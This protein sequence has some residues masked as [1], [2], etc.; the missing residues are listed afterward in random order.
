MSLSLF[1]AKLNQNT[2]AAESLH[3][4]WNQR[5]LKTFHILTEVEKSPSFLVPEVFEGRKE[6]GFPFIFLHSHKSSGRCDSSRFLSAVKNICS[7]VD[8]KNGDISKMEIHS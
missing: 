6:S 8:K 5:N 2:S 4:R 1:P 7:A 3:R